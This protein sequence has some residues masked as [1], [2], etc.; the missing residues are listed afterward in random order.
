MEKIEIIPEQYASIITIWY[1]PEEVW[2]RQGPPPN[3]EIIKK[4]FAKDP[5]F[6]KKLEDLFKKDIEEM[7]KG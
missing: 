4:W 5:E 2:D 1:G 6:D 7:Q 3:K